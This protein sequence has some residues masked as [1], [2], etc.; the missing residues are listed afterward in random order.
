MD[1]W[2]DGPCSNEHLM[3]GFVCFDWVKIVSISNTPLGGGGGR[4]ESYFLKANV[5]P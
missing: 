5:F 2:R 4:G 1:E 3:I